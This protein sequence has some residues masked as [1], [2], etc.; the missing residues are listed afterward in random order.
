MTSNKISWVEI[1]AAL[2]VVASLVFVGFELRQSNQLARIQAQQSMGEAWS[3]VNLTMATDHELM[4]L[5]ARMASG[6]IEADF[7]PGEIYSL[8]LVLHGLDHTWEMYF[9]QMQ[10]GVLQK[11]DISF[12]P[13]NNRTF[14]SSFHRELW[15]NIRAGFDE[16]FAVFWEQ[17]FG[18][19]DE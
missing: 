12:P 11:G 14:R 18:L 5:M 7:E 2:G 6:E 15:P 16:G 3:T 17:R 9:K 1:V 10:S 19:V 4:V 13:P 8:Y